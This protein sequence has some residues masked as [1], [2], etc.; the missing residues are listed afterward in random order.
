MSIAVFAAYHIISVYGDAENT[1]DQILTVS[2]LL[3]TVMGI[4]VSAKILMAVNKSQTT[5]MSEYL[6]QTI[7]IIRKAQ[8]NNIVYVISPTY[9]PGLTKI[10]TSNMLDDLFT[11]IKSKQKKGVKFRYAFLQTNFQH[12]PDF[13]VMKTSMDVNKNYL[14]EISK[15]D[16][17]WYMYKVF[18]EKEYGKI[19]KNNVADKI[20]FVEAKYNEL[21][22]YYNSIK[23]IKDSINITNNNTTLT[24]PCELKEDYKKSDADTTNSF[25]GFF[26]TANISKGKYYLGSFHYDGVKTTFDGTVFKNSYIKNE[27]KDL[28]DGYILKYRM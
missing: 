14:E 19:K 3:L 27:M 15:D 9:C 24:F 18:Y 12:K 1:Q 21:E 25:S 11:I 10:E 2:G 17:H 22:R 28:F 26:V 7:D 16:F 8:G 5:E 4:F 20:D 13:E 6:S 23:L